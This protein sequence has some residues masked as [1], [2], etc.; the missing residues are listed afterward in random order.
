MHP[1]D[2]GQ[3]AEIKTSTRY[4]LYTWG[5]VTY[6][7]AFDREWETRF[8]Y[9][10]DASSYPTTTLEACLTGNCADKECKSDDHMQGRT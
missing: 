6:K 1:P 9:S 3:F 4:R 5:I 7:D 10:L 2:Q 8:C